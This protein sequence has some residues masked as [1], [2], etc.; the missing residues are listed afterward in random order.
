M[1]TYFTAVVAK[2]RGGEELK[3]AQC[4]LCKATVLTKDYTTGPMIGHL[5]AHHMDEFHVVRADIDAKKASKVARDKARDV[6]NAKAG[7]HAPIPTGKLT[8]LRMNDVEY[9]FLSS[10]SGKSVL[11]TVNPVETDEKTFL[12]SS[13]KKKSIYRI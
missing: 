8:F 7:V 11:N 1:W 10:N 5:E 6:A 12:T 4:T 9:V 13:F 2:G 3:A